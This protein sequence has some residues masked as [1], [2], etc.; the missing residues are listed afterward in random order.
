MCKNMS[1]LFLLGWFFSLSWLPLFLLEWFKYFH[2]GFDTKFRGLFVSNLFR[3]FLDFIYFRAFLYLINEVREGNLWRIRIVFVRI[4]RVFLS[5]LL[6]CQRRCFTNLL[7]YWLLFL[8]F[9]EYTKLSNFVFRESIQTALIT[10]KRHLRFT[11][12]FCNNLNF[13]VHL[14]ALNVRLCVLYLN[15]L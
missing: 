1:S 8:V 2:L 14:P 7:E 15:L 13:L 3:W 11:I 6:F 5:L 4:L 10:Q 12:I 9:L